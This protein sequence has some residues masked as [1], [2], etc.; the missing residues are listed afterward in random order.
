MLHPQS[1]HRTLNSQ[2]V[3]PMADEKLSERGEHHRCLDEIRS[4][5]HDRIKQIDEVIDHENIFRT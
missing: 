2:T 1:L 5:L 4:N 3:D